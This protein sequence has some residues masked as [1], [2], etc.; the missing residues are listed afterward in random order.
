MLA[1]GAAR[2]QNKSRL[3]LTQRLDEKLRDAADDCLQKMVTSE[4]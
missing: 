4:M 1:V 2:K 3:A